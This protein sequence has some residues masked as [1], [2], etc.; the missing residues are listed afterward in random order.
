MV[1]AVPVAVELDVEVADVEAVTF[2]AA[3]G[4]GT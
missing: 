3:A 4:L 2:D 1:V